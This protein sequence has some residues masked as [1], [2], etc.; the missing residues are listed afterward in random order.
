MKVKVDIDPNDFD[1]IFNDLFGTPAEP[2]VSTQPETQEKVN[3][4][5]PVLEC[6]HRDWYT[7]D[8]HDNAR[9][10]GFCCQGGV[11]KQAKV[12]DRTSGY[13]PIKLQYDIK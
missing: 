2:E 11:K 5:I 1:D 7:Q 12:W 6:G 10:Q 8:E 4:G 9:Q 13:I 3:T